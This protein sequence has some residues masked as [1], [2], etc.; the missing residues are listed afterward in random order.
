MNRQMPLFRTAHLGFTHTG[1][2][3]VGPKQPGRE[4]V[5]YLGR[6]KHGEGIMFQVTSAFSLSLTHTHTFH[7]QW[8]PGK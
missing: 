4:E 3:Q 5:D 7:M 8:D 1:H 6:G 2:T